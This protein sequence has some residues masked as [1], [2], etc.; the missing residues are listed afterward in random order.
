MNKNPCP[1]VSARVVY[2]DPKMAADLLR[3]NPEH[4]RN[5]K[6]ANLHK[7]EADL[8]AGKFVVNGQTVIRDEKKRLMDGQHRLQAVVNTGI[9]IWTIL[10]SDIPEEYFR[11]IDVGVARS[12]A[13][14]LT[15]TER[16]QTKSLAAAVAR[17]AEYLRN[18]QSVG[19]GAVFSHSELLDV[20]EMSP[21]FEEALRAV[22]VC[23]QLITPSQLT[24]LYYLA[25]QEDPD[26][27]DA[28]IRGIAYGEMLTKTS[29]IYQLRLR[30]I[31]G[32][33][34]GYHPGPREMQALFIKTWN[35]YLRG[36]QMKLLQWQTPRETFPALELPAKARAAAG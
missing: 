9:G 28:F 26:K 5:I 1:Q 17:L 27:A 13:D 7:I 18:P 35:A 10:V 29:P 21:G 25:R 15:T 24:W 3:T 32:K 11:L 14:T 31:T 34:Q 12:F 8:R 36:E 33:S 2:I 30:L 16:K 19:S 23:K 22:G 6:P 20:V 4:Q